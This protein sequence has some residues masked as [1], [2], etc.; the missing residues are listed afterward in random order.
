VRKE[1]LKALPVWLVAVAGM[2]GMTGCDRELPY[3]APAEQPISGYFV[4]GYVTDRLGIP[5]K[6]LKIALRYNL[7]YIDSNNPPVRQFLVDDS[8]KVARV[9][10]LDRSNRVRRILFQG[11]RSVGLLDVDF[12]LRD[13]AGALLPTGLYTVSFT[14]DGVSKGAYTQLVNSSVTTTTDS[15]GHYAIPDEFLPVGFYPV[16]V[17]AG[18][19]V[20]F[21]GN[22]QISSFIVLEF[23][24]PTHKSAAVTVTQD[25][26]TR[27]DYRI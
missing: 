20:R 19:G 17:Y 26:I 2:A 12:D 21:I 11:R 8:T 1:L 15:L 25:K 3:M 10:V 5:V 4:E 9:A 16:P 27:F 24:L 22:Y 23:Y 7:D 14:L 18:D 6:G 13:S